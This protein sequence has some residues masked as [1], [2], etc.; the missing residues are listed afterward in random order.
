MWRRPA[1]HRAPPTLSPP[2]QEIVGQ[3]RRRDAPRRTTQRVDIAALER[4]HEFEHRLRVSTHRKHALLS[5]PPP[6]ETAWSMHKDHVEWTRNRG[7]GGVWPKAPME[8]STILAHMEKRRLMLAAK[9]PPPEIV[10]KPAHRPPPGWSVPEG[11]WPV[12]WS[13]TDCSF[14]PPSLSWST[15]KPPQSN[16]ATPKKKL[17]S[18]AGSGVTSA[19]SPSVL[20]RRPELWAPLDV[21]SMG[22]AKP[23][24]LLALLSEGVGALTM[25][26]KTVPRLL[27]L[28]SE[29]DS[30]DEAKGDS[31]TSGGSHINGK[32]DG[33]DGSDG[34]DGDGDGDG[35][36]GNG[37][38]DGE[39]KD[40]DDA[41]FARYR[42]F[43]KSAADDH[44]A[45]DDASPQGGAA[46]N[47][48]GA[49][50]C[51]NVTRR[52]FQ[53]RALHANN[54]QLA[55]IDELPSVVARLLLEPHALVTLD[56]SSNRI[57]HIPEAFG[58][59]AALEV[60]QLHH[61]AL[62]HI[63]ELIHLRPLA[64]LARL[65]LM[66]NPLTMQRMSSVDILALKTAS[67]L[68]SD[69]TYQVE[70]KPKAYRLKV[71]ARLPTLRQLDL[72]PVTST[73]KE[74]A[75]LVGIHVSK[76][77]EGALRSRPHLKDA[78]NQA[79]YYRAGARPHAAA[80][81]AATSEW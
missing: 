58:T 35:G 2:S 48:D 55:S 79:K 3:P 26:G 11:G 77:D 27:R 17:S 71:L 36:D 21:A 72:M 46:Q 67:P 64:S 15:P 8:S 5:R 32:D 28:R 24:E 19:V 13:V 41:D 80:T 78:A 18:E 54:N 34:G 61:N 45:M 37:D 31:D 14:R 43:E 44:D 65:T 50:E 12:R 9:A 59:L 70:Y 39:A 30:N 51:S 52:A 74:E 4:R 81:A 23:E 76:R 53:T 66:Y 68:F 57:A 60:L 10:W 6:P 56:L 75:A 42:L 22:Y 47:A 62:A 38:G 1:L 25:A 7:G 49:R 73:E 20:R 29:G 40:D 33:G 63:A 69:S 16:G